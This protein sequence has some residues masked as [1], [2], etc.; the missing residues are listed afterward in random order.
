MPA[1]LRIVKGQSSRH[2]RQIEKSS[3]SIGGSSPSDLVFPGLPKH[4]FSLEYREGEYWLLNT[5]K[6]LLY[7]GDRVIA[8]KQKSAWVPGMNVQIGN[9]MVLTLET[10]RD[11]APTP[12]RRSWLGVTNRKLL[13][14][15]QAAEQGKRQR[16]LTLIGVAVAGSALLFLASLANPMNPEVEDAKHFAMIAETI[17][18]NEVLENSVGERFR[19]ARLA[20]L[21]GQ[22]ATAQRYLSKIRERL[23]LLLEEDRSI[24]METFET[25]ARY[26]SRKTN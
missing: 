12:L 13:N 7:S 22:T 23:R 4:T 26:I 25:V 8:P 14:R 24:D 15:D 19:N 17:E 20:E 3:S 10:D 11:P 21:Q 18:K 1:R 9:L 5:G 6:E 16:L 2:V